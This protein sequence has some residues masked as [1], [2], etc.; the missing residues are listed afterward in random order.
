[1]V[2]SKCAPCHLHERLLLESSDLRRKLCSK[3]RHKFLALPQGQIWDLVQWEMITDQ[4]TAPNPSIGMQSQANACERFCKYLSASRNP[5]SDH[6]NGS[7][8]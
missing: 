8:S 1:M 5:G 3:S 2:E 6:V 7:K 4:E